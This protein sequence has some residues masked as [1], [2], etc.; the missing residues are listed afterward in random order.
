MK[1][2]IN[3]KVW[4]RGEGSL[5]SRLL[6]SRDGKRCCLGIALGDAGVP[7]EAL[8]EMRAP[9]EVVMQGTSL[10][11]KFRWLIDDKFL[12]HSETTT[13]LMSANDYEGYTEQEREQRVSELFAKEGV[14]V[15]FHDGN[16]ES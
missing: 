5:S 15:E 8:C 14:E 2:R 13:L 12:W 11:D 7:D 3:R 16:A 4:L 9:G 10:P 6:R 1:Q